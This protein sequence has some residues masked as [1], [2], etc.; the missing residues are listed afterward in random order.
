MVY[1]TRPLQS[2]VLF[3]F[4]L[5]WWP[6]KKIL[7]TLTTLLLYNVRTTT[8]TTSAAT[9]DLCFP[10]DGL[11][12]IS[13]VTA[14]VRLY[15]YFDSQRGDFAKSPTKLCWIIIAFPTRFVNR[16]FREIINVTEKKAPKSIYCKSIAYERNVVFKKQKKSKA[17]SKPTSRSRDTNASTTSSVKNGELL[18]LSRLKLLSS[19]YIDTLSK[20]HLRLFLFFFTTLRL[21]QKLQ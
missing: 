11:S 20:Q 9:T 16:V 12:F 3:H 18:L 19:V 14:I 2:K 21:L 1:E 6:K 8:T 4:D 7:T 17:P 15:R 10:R 5:F 13:C